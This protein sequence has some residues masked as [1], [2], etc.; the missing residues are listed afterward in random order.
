MS[1][2][3][4]LTTHFPP[5]DLRPFSQAAQDTQGCEWVYKWWLYLNLLCSVQCQ[6]KDEV[7]VGD[8]LYILLLSPNLH[9]IPAWCFSFLVFFSVFLFFFKLS[10]FA[11]GN[12]WATV[13]GFLFFCWVSLHW[14]GG[15]LQLPASLCNS[16]R[17]RVCPSWCLWD[18]ISM[19]DLCFTGGLFCF[20]SF[21]F[22]VAG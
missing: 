8:P 14:S 17:L 16:P 21:C 22:S 5:L 3:C 12:G 2:H 18:W 19:L 6:H 10:T 9:W 7:F 11:F 13:L 1:I 20:V 15:V 4:W